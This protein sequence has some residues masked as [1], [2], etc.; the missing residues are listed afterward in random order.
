MIRLRYLEVFLPK[1]YKFL[2]AKNIYLQFL[3]V[4]ISRSNSKIVNNTRNTL[5]LGQNTSKYRSQIIV[6][7]VHANGL[8]KVHTACH[9]IVN[10]IKPGSDSK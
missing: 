8:P 2:V 10:G 5:Y 6:F 1:M 3:L 4:N 9:N 7:Y